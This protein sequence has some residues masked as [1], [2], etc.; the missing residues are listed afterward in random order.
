[1]LCATCDNLWPLCASRKS[2]WQIGVYS[3]V[4]RIYCR[5]GTKNYDRRRLTCKFMTLFHYA[6]ISFFFFFHPIRILICFWKFL[7]EKNAI[8]VLKIYIYISVVRTREQYRFLLVHLLF[9]KSNNFN[10]IQ[11]AS[12]FLS[13]HSSIR[14]ILP[15]NGFHPLFSSR[16]LQSE[17][18]LYM[19]HPPT[20]FRL[21]RGAPINKTISRRHVP[22]NP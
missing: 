13:F 1:M 7:E 14:E 15:A 3:A 10:S 22:R 18:R 9:H 5:S 6:P 2:R 4:Q 17:I 19:V 11:F 12:I 8:R 16:A 21:E 20:I